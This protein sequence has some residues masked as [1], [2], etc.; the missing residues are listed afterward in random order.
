MLACRLPAL[1]MAKPSP[2]N[3]R[4]VDPD[5]PAAGAPEI[6]ATFNVDL[7]QPGCLTG[8]FFI[9]FDNIHGANID[10]IT[11][12]LHEFGHGLGFQTFTS[13]STGAQNS[14]SQRFLTD[15]SWTSTPARAGCK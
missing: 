13:A 11:V 10:L 14:G 15:F 7:G 2:T 6:N 9:G 1:G 8:T 4:R 3:S 5:H 12:L